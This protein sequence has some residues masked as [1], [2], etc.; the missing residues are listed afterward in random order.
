MSTPVSLSVEAPLIELYTVMLRIRRFEER[1]A[2]EFR[3][4]KIPGFAHSY[5]GSEAIA[6]GV[7]AWL[8]DEDVITSTHRGHG[9]C[10]AKGS[11]L[12]RMFAE[13]A[14]REP[15]LCHGR[16]GSM[17]VADFSRG[18]RGANAIVGGGISLATGAALAAKVSRDGRIAIAFF[19]DGAVNQGVFHESLNLA[20]IWNLPVVYVCE[21][22]GW[23]EST[24]FAYATSTPRVVDRAAGYGVQGMHVDAGDVREVYRAA[25]EAIGRAREGA[26]PTLLEITTRRFEGHYIGDGEKYRTEERV[27]RRQ[28]D[29]VMLARSQIVYESL[30]SPAEL[31]TLD[32]AVQE[33]V[34]AAANFAL[35]APWPRAEDVAVYVYHDPRAATP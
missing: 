13:I 25:G 17:H 26:G 33:S 16:G 34:D 24:P 20:A 31:D 8:T 1:V 35:G 14:G 29:P 28:A 32:T 2:S 30:L 5:L 12:D 7:C 6:A 9:H 10:I 21:N 23:A 27:E 3:R 19:G 18:V 4:G 22:N 15:G 11:D